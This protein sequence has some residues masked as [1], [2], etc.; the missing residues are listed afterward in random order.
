MRNQTNQTYDIIKKRIMEG[1][2]HPSESLAELGLATDLGVSRSTVK[3]A[4]LMLES[5]NLVVIEESRRARVRS[6]SVEEMQQYLELR[7]LVEGFVARLSAPFLTEGDLAEMR[8][9][10]AEMKHCLEIHELLE[11][12]KNN[13]KFHEVIYRACPNKPAVEMV[14]SIKNQFRRYNVRTI[15]VKG[16]DEKSFAEH[17]A[18]LEA[19]EARDGEK[20]EEV[21]RAHIAN[22]SEVIRKNSA[23]LF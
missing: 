13:W 2:Y 20:V 9:I 14:M 12:S 10:L 16:R 23:I 1:I 22:M 21:M 19:L 6:F 8:A 5:E 11:Y 7:M 3:K 17:S 4:L 15:L 18:I